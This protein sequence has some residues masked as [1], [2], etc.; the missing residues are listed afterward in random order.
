MGGEGEALEEEDGLGRE[1]EENGNGAVNQV[2]S[3]Q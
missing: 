2:S 1:G 3:F